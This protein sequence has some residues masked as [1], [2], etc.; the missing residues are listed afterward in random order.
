MEG[1]RTP[2]GAETVINAGTHPAVREIPAHGGRAEMMIVKYIVGTLDR[3]GLLRRDLDYHLLRA[4]MVII[5]AWFGWD[6]WHADEI[7]Q[8]IPLITHGP[9]IFWTIPVLGVRGTSILLGA[10]EWTFGLLIFLGFWDKR[11]GLLGALGSIA[12]FVATVTIFPFAPDGWDEAAGGFPSMS[13]TTAF[14]LKDLVLLTVSFFLL[15]EDALRLVAART[16]R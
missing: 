6:K 9:L 12:T 3:L 16:G 5:F 4:A 7:R 2:A 14:L 13:I 11:L 8:L 1:A 10:S 15:R